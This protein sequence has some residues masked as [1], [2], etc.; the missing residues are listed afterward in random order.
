MNGCGARGAPTGLRNEEVIE[1]YKSK[2]DLPETLKK[3][4][5]EDLQEIYLEAYQKSWKGYEDFRGGEA[6]QEAVAHR[7][8]MTAVELDHV[9]HEETGEWYR[10][11]EEPE[12]EKEKGILDQL[13]DVVEAL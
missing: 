1:M 8:A 2:S 6:G 12:G 10:K 5:P 7:D 13:K 4:L 11:G 3:Y 9:Y